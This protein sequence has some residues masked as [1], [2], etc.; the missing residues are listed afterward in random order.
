MQ[1]N[2]TNSA[3]NGTPTFP[4]T[5]QNCTNLSLITQYRS[6]YPPQFNYNPGWTMKKLQ[7]RQIYLF[8]DSY[9]RPTIWNRCPIHFGS[10]SARTFCCFPEN[11]KH[12]HGW[13]STQLVLRGAC[14]VAEVVAVVVVSASLRA[15][16]LSWLQSNSTVSFFGTQ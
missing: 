5:F 4:Q 12:N 8:I 2:S 16:I 14:R 9:C 13:C 6:I 11:L 1:N 15:F 7:N 10:C 3:E